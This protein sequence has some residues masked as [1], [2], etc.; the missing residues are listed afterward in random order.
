MLE[1]KWYAILRY[2]TLESGG[3]GPPVKEPGALL[4]GAP[5]GDKEPQVGTEPVKQAAHP[6][7]H[8]F[9]VNY[10]SGACE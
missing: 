4:T 5:E 8:K 1:I 3:I 10:L 2:P 9:L 7:A 6:N